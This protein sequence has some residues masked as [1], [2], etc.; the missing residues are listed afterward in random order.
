LPKVLS[1]NDNTAIDP[2]ILILLSSTE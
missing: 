2:E 1:S